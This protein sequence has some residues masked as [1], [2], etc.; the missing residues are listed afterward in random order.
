M[1]G[2]TLGGRWPHLSGMG[3]SLTSGSLDGCRSP[4]DR[5][6]RRYKSM[7]KF[8]REMEIIYFLFPASWKDNP[9]SVPTR[10]ELEKKVLFKSFCHEHDYI[11]IYVA[12]ILME[13]I[14]S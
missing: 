6:Q 1:T 4:R 9:P 12:D 11:T 3:G 13:N 8:P 5:R 7:F 14:L 2:L 10:Q